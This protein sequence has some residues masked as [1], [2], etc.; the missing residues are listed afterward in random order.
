MKQV[1]AILTAMAMVL[2]MQSAFAAGQFGPMKEAEF[3]DTEEARKRGAEIVIS[4]CLV[5]HSLKYVKYRDL[6]DIGMTKEKIKSLMA[7]EALE[8]RMLSLTPIEIRKESYGLVPPDLSLMA[9]ARKKG[10]EHIYTLLTSYYTTADGEADNHFFPKIK[11]PDML[12]YSFT[13]EGSEARAAIEKQAKDA[14][15]FLIWTADPNAEARRTIGTFV[16]LYLIILT[17]LLYLVKK[18]IWKRVPKIER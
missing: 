17:T 13:E 2:G 8:D 11:M 14:V 15:S 3:E 16:I 6:L 1:L 12:G 5:C 7:D 18:R 10:P 4:V 9:I